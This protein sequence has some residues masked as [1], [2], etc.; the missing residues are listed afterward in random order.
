MRLMARSDVGCKAWA[1]KA[2]YFPY[3]NAEANINMHDC[4]YISETVTKTLVI[5]FTRNRPNK[6]YNGA[7]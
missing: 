7:S 1:N 5:Y 4:S 3:R 6:Y 2:A